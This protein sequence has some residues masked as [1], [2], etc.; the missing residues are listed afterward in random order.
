MATMFCTSHV[1]LTTSGGSAQL[2]LTNVGVWP[3]A[4][5]PTFSAAM[6]RHGTL[7]LG[8]SPRLYA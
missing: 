5:P 1:T 8:R 3:H 4:L 2:V 6:A 7:A